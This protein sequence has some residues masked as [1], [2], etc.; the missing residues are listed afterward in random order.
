MLGNPGVDG[1]SISLPKTLRRTTI[2]SRLLGGGF[3]GVGSLR[4]L[5]GSLKG[6]LHKASIQSDGAEG[7][8]SKP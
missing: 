8:S 3:W 4:I 7:I 1:W 6:S 2:A 5:T